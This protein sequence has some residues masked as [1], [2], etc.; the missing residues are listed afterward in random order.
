M[1][2][3]EPGVGFRL[4]MILESARVHLKSQSG[5]ALSLVTSVHQPWLAQRSPLLRVNSN[6]FHVVWRMAQTSSF[7]VCGAP[8]SW[9]GKT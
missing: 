1:R 4:N 9:R 6:D 8:I 2:F 3:T 7:D 5:S